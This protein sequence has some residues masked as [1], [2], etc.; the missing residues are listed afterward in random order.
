MIGDFGD[1]NPDKPDFKP[2][3]M[4]PENWTEFRGGQET[5]AQQGIQD[6]GAKLEIHKV[7][8]L[9]D[10]QGIYLSLHKWL[11]ERDFPIEGGLVLSRLAFFQIY[12]VLSRSKQ[13]P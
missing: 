5:A 7:L 13:W 3:E 10:L 11:R 8:V 2:K 12:D 9:V 4:T 1:R 6:V